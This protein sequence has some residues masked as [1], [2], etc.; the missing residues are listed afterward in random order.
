MRALPKSS[1]KRKVVVQGLANHVGNIEKNKIEKKIKLS[2]D[3]SKKDKL[4]IDF[5]CRTDIV[6]AIPSLKD[7]MMGKNPTV[8]ENS[9]KKKLRKYFL[10]WFLRGKCY[11]SINLWRGNAFFCVL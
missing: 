11:F 7:E 8:W 5:Y 2:S 4:V 3:I 10:T 9:K 1:T 6:Y